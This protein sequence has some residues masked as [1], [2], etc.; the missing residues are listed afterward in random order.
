MPEGLVVSAHYQ[1]MPMAIINEQD[2]VV[3]FQFHPES[4]LTSEGAT[5]L[6]RSLDWAIQQEQA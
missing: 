4:I 3:G 6:A 1:K 5:L 2:K